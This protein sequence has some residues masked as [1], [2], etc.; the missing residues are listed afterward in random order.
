MA[1]T[2]FC[3][4]AAG[5]DV[6]EEEEGYT[7]LLASRIS[8]SVDQQNSQPPQLKELESLYQQHLHAVTPA[9]NTCRC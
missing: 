6:T 3:L 1:G 8:A 5:M 4:A 2:G 9:E 7:S